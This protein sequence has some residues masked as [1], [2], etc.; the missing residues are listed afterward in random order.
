[1]KD[2]LLID[3][4][5]PNNFSAKTMET[6]NYLRNKLSNRSKNHGKVIPKKASIGQRQDLS[7]VCIFGNLL[8]ANIPQKK[9][10]K[11]DFQK[12]WQNILIGY[13]PDIIKYFCVWASQTKQVI[14]ADKSY[15]H[16]SE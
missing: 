11:S 6:T 10:S 3:I 8:L 12:V 13:S 2:L 16:E 7:Y 9:R 1:M 4:G 14:I 5:L 15:I